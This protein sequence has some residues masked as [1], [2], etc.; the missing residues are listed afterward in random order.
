MKRRRMTVHEWRA[1]ATR[2]F[3][4]DPKKWRF[5]CVRCGNVQSFESVIEHNPALAPK[6][7]EAEG[8]SRIWRW[9]N[10]ACEGRHTEG[11]GCDWTLGGLFQIHTLE[12]IDESG[13]IHPSFE[14]DEAIESVGNDH[15][16]AE[17]A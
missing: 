11:R 1:K 3:G 10:F 16:S 4:P 8:D 13:T 2:L 5:R 17:S 9:I 15:E 12:I 6:D 14:F 7:G